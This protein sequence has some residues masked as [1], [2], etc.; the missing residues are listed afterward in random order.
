ML[1]EAGQLE[2]ATAMFER[3]LD[4]TRTVFGEHHRSVVTQLHALGVIAAK[5]VRAERGGWGSCSRVG[6][7]GAMV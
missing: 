7:C 5:Q 1:Q 3:A 2:G 4:I 6:V